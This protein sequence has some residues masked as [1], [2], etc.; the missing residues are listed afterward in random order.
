MQKTLRA[1]ACAQHRPKARRLSPCAI[2]SLAILTRK[3]RYLRPFWSPGWQ[4]GAHFCL[5]KSTCQTFVAVHSAI[6]PQHLCTQL[7]F[8]ERLCTIGLHT[9]VGRPTAVPSVL[10]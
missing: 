6:S 3:I 5:K 7:G 10:T 8:V 4:L 1:K 2:E 9:L